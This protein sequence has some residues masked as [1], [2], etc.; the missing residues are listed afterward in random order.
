M[1]EENYDISLDEMEALFQEAEELLEQSTSFAQIGKFDFR[2]A[3]KIYTGGQFVEVGVK[4]WRAYPEFKII[5]LVVT[6]DTQEFNPNLQFGYERKIQVDRAPWNRKGEDGK[7]EKVLSDWFAIWLPS[8]KEVVPNYTTMPKALQYLKGKY[9][10][11][12]DVLQQPTKQQPEPTYKTCKLVKVYESREEAYQDYATTFETAN[13][14]VPESVAQQEK[15]AYSQELIDGVNQ[16][17]K[18]NVTDPKII[19]QSIGGNLTAQDVK[20]ILGE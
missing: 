11:A 12:L 14:D 10:K 19:A 4:E 8:V 1:V 2:T 13:E 16:L 15:P 9:V 6:I 3:P 17:I 20:N 7:T 5:E 18:L